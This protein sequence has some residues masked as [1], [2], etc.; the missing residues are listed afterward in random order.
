VTPKAHWSAGN[1]NLAPLIISGATIKENEY[2]FVLPF[3]KWSRGPK[4]S[5]RKNK[6]VEEKPKDA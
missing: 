4:Q 2:G 1:E 6:R 5:A 3:L